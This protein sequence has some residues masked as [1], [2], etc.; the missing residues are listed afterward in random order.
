MPDDLYN[1]DILV[2]AEHQAALLR[3]LASGERVN[4]ALD[5]PNLIEEVEDVGRAQLQTCESLLRQAMLHLLKLHLGADQPAAHW[6]S[7]TLG[8]LGDAAAR[9]TPAMRQRID[10]DLL[11][12]R[13]TRQAAL[14]VPGAAGLPN[15]CPWTLDLLLSD[16]ADINELLS[17]L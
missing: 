2:W 13:A 3:R 14:S 16:T 4:E 6:R 9:F 5:W 7:E 17:G 10:L 12:A 11:Y 1:R 8:F 15:T